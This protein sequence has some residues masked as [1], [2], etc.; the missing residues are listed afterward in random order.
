MDRVASKLRQK[1]AVIRAL[2]AMSGT[3]LDGVDAAVLE[4]DGITIKG[5]GPV[6]YLSYTVKQRQVLHAALG[7]WNGDSLSRATDVVIEAHRALLGRFA[8]VDLIGFHGQT[9]AHAPRNQGTLQLGD[10][11]AL[12]DFISGPGTWAGFMPDHPGS[13]VVRMTSTAPVE[14]AN[15]AGVGFYIPPDFEE[16]VRGKRVRVSAE[17]R[18]GG[19]GLETARLAYFTVA[20]GDSGWREVPLSDEFATVSFEWTAPDGEVN[21]QEWVGFWPDPEGLAREVILRRVWVEI[22]EEE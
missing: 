1:G 16:A 2:G 22:L 12:A 20:N 7:H 13:P 18:R 4:T 15:S 17:L 9:V 3:S 10:G 21:E 8:Q 11:A 14:N 5:F 6:E 19:G